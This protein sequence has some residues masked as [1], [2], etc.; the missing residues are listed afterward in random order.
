MKPEFK[1]LH[2]N[3]FTQEIRDQ[4]IDLG[5]RSGVW[6]ESDIEYY[7]KQFPN[8]R[9]INIVYQNEVGFIT[10]YIL[11]KPH[12]EAVLD[13]LVE[14]PEMRM[15]EAGMF[16]VDVV[17]TDVK[18]NHASVGMHL[19]N[20][21]IKESNHLG[22][23]R[24]S[25]HCRVINGFSKIIQRKFRSGVEVVRRIEKYVDCNNEPADYMEVVVVL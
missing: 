1:L 6:Q 10:G 21:L 25:L 13:Y 18:Q 22:V 8:P 16:Y 4:I 7:K 24:F 20:E 3:D 14:D 23:S 17:I 11:A 5:K 15:S 19:I 12:N 9:N 2:P